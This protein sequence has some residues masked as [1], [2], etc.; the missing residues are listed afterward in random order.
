MELHQKVLPDV[1]QVGVSLEFRLAKDEAGT[2]IITDGRLAVNDDDQNEQQ[3]ISF[4]DVELAQD[5]TYYFLYALQ[6]S[7]QLSLA[8]VTLQ[9]VDQSDITLPSIL[10]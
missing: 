5:E 3:E 4:G 7:S 9:N 2:D 1:R 6:S 8:T 10:T